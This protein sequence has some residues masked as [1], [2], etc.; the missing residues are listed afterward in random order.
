M[1]SSAGYVSSSEALYPFFDGNPWTIQV[2]RDKT[3]GMNYNA[4]ETL[5]HVGV[6]NSPY[7]GDDGAYLG[8]NDRSATFIRS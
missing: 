8:Y 3:F 6:A 2:G 4:V 1:S 7:E 5:Y